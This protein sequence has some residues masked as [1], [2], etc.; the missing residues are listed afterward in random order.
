MDSE[1]CS[2]KRLAL[3]RSESLPDVVR[4][5]SKINRRELIA[6]LR[7]SNSHLD[8]ADLCALGAL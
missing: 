7:G 5:R 2:G 6:P 3:E 8:V 1:V 4:E